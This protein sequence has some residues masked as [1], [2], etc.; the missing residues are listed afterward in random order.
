MA[1]SLSYERLR[2]TVWETFKTSRWLIAWSK[3][4][5]LKF[6]KRIIQTRETETPPRILTSCLHLKKQNKTKSWKTN[7]KRTSHWG[8][9]SAISSLIFG[10]QQLSLLL[11]AVVAEANLQEATDCTRRQIKNWAQ[12]SMFC[13]LLT[14]WGLRSIWVKYTL[15]HINWCSLSFSKSTLF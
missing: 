12:S 6:K 4:S 10:R 5:T 8:I 3:S 2:T 7:L 15:K 9:F 14:C 1:F 11:T 13:E